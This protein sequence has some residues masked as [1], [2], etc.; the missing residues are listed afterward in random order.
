MAVGAPGPIRPTRPGVRLT[1]VDFVA[2]L[3]L[4]QILVAAAAVKRKIG[5]KITHLERGRRRESP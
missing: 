4:E 1:P 3:A 5:E 2:A